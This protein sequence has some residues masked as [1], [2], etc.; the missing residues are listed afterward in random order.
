VMKDT[1]RQACLTAN[2]ACTFEE[3]GR[4]RIH[5]NPSAPIFSDPSSACIHILDIVQAHS[6]LEDKDASSGDNDT[7]DSSWG[8]CGCWC[9]GWRTSHASILS[10]ICRQ[11]LSHLLHFDNTHILQVYPPILARIP[12]FEP[13]T[14]FATPHAARSGPQS[15]NSAYQSIFGHFPGAPGSPTDDLAEHTSRISL[16]PSYLY[17]DDEGYT[18]W[19]GETSG[20]ALLDL[21]V[22]NIPKDKKRNQRTRIIPI[23]LIEC[24]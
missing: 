3:P 17:F 8:L 9:Y 11:Y 18:R 16:S 7:V 1:H 14:H 6:D 13:S 20:S 12:A 2:S 10:R 4:G 21:I 15:P 19:Q 22:E 23:F 5:N 24:R